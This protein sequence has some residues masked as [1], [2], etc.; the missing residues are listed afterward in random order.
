[1]L[2]MGIRTRRHYYN[3]TALDFHVN[4]HSSTSGDVLGLLA[5]LLLRMLARAVGLVAGVPGQGGRSTA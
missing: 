5:H 2:Y 1:M 3:R 4:S